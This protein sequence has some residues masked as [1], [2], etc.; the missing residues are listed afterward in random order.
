MPTVSFISQIIIFLTN[1]AS[2]NTSTNLYTNRL[3]P[4]RSCI[5]QQSF[6]ASTKSL[7]N[8]T[9]LQTNENTSAHRQSHA[10]KHISL[11]KGSRKVLSTGMARQPAVMMKTITVL[12]HNY[13]EYQQEPIYQTCHWDTPLFLLSRCRPLG[14]P[15]ISSSIRGSHILW[16]MMRA[17]EVM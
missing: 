1:I 7:N 3:K 11:L 12:P 15:I 8:I 14:L 16:S 9:P 10:H 17:V 5:K 13:L 6:F 4:K 2:T